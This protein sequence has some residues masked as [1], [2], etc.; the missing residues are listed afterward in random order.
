[1]GRLK[2]LLRQP[3]LRSQERVL[4]AIAAVLVVLLASFPAVG[5]AYIITVVRDAL[6]FGLLALSLDFFWGRTNL[7][8]FGHSV[9]FGLGAYAMAVVT[10][11]VGGSLASVV[12]ILVAVGVATLAAGLLG[13]FLFFGEVRGAY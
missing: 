2:H 1:M 5:S 7:L 8:S 3:K 6:I 4:I 11:D 9:F 12:G 10:L 13:V